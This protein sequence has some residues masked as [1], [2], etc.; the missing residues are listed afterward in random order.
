M[1]IYKY[2]GYLCKLADNG[3]VLFRNSKERWL[4]VWSEIDLEWAVEKGFME[5]SAPMLECGENPMQEYY[6][7]TKKGR[8]LAEWYIYPTWFYIKYK[9]THWHLFSRNK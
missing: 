8:M 7:M 4:S 5:L 6:G 3:N 9:I 2:F 1:T